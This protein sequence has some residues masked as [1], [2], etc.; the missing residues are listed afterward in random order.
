MKI[1]A[2]ISVLDPRFTFVLL[3]F[4]WERRPTTDDFAWGCRHL[5]HFIWAWRA[6]RGEVLQAIITKMPPAC[7][8]QVRGASEIEGRSILV[9]M[10]T[11]ASVGY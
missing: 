7:P 1:G 9:T 8:A 3:C 11:N 2:L 4:L 5:P 10:L 6:G